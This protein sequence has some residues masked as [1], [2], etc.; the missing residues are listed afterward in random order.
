MGVVVP[1]EGNDEASDAGLDWA[2]D[3]RY[4]VYRDDIG[5]GGA[6][7]GDDGKEELGGPDGAEDSREAPAPDVLAD[8]I[9]YLDAADCGGGGERNTLA[10]AAEM[11]AAYW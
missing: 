10:E 1:D 9:P 7:K 11:G 4:E 3:G 5:V 6:L 2:G 8:I